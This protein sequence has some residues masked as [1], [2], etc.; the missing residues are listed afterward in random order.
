MKVLLVG[1]GAREHALAWRLA[2]SP[3]ATELHAAPGNPGIARLGRCHPVRTDDVE[4]MVELARSLAVD[5]VVVGPE[6]PLVAGL[7]DELRHV[8]LSVFGPGAAA[9]RIEGSKLFAKEVMAAAGVLPAREL[10]EAR[11][12]CVIKADG[13]AAGK[14]VFVC[15]TDE[16]VAAGLRDAA[17]LG[18]EIVVE[19]LL[20]GPEVSLFAL[21]DGT[22]AI[23]FGTAQDFKRAFDGDEGP[24]TGGMGAFSPRRSTT[25]RPSSWPRSTSP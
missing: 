5:L 18:A 4:G 21:C 19:E 17:A 15:R 20:E 14:G 3:L 23:P 13:L 24:N 12:P 25:T 11:A 6:V 10:D 8:G 1:S 22:R 7:A 2:T 16:E 9:A